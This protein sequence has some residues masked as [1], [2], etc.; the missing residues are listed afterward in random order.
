MWSAVTRHRFLK[1]TCRRRQPA[2]RAAHGHP[3]LAPAVARPQV[4]SRS[5]VRQRPV[6]GAKAVPGPAL[7]TDRRTVTL[8][9][10]RSD[11]SR[12]TVQRGQAVT[13]SSMS[14]LGWTSARNPLRFIPSLRCSDPPPPGRGRTLT[15]PP[16]QNTAE[17]G[18]N[19]EQPGVTLNC[20]GKRSA[21]TRSPAFVGKTSFDDSYKE[22][23][24]SP[25]SKARWRAGDCS[26]VPV[27]QASLPRVPG[28]APPPVRRGDGRHGCRPNWQAR[29][30]A[31]QARA[32]R[33]CHPL[34]GKVSGQPLEP[35]AKPLLVYLLP[36]LFYHLYPVSSSK[37]QASGKR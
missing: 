26:T 13:V 4:Q 12:E 32:S 25:H 18:R 7:D 29:T 22:P 10:A 34:V 28:F 15:R 1:A 6:A 36:T 5:C 23:D 11:G 8:V 37:A 30:P 21:T 14:I 33:P 16:A 9:V 31:P 20:G 19:A 35:L 3:P 17:M 24:G 27:R 2:T